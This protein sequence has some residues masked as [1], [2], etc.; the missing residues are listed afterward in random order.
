MQIKLNNI[1]CSLIILMPALLITGSFL[2]DSAV[3]L[4]DLIFIYFLFKEKKFDII[5]NNLFKLLIL[6][7]I[8]ISIRSIFTEDVLLSLK[9]SM[10]YFRFTF[11]IFA[12]GFFLHKNDKLIYYFSKGII[13]T[14]LILCLDALFQFF[15]GFNT[16]GFKIINLDKLNSFF[17]D[18]AVLGS[19]LIRFL[20]LLLACFLHLFS[21][22]KKHLFHILLLFIGVLI[23][24]SGSRSS[25]VLF[26]I[27]FLIL[28]TLFSNYRKIILINFFILMSLLTLLLLKY[29]FNK[30][31]KNQYHD[32][33]IKYKMYYNII[34]P[35]KSIFIEN[36]KTDKIIIFTKIYQTHYE[37]AYKMFNDN[38]I[39]GVGNKMY[40]KLCDDPKYYISKHSCTTH[41]HNFY[42]QIL[43]ENGLVGFLF[44]LSLFLY[45]CLQL[46][47]EFY[48]RNIKKQ[49]NLDNKSLLI[50][51]GIFLNLWPIIPSGNFYNNWLSI[52]IY[53]PIGFL[54]YF[55]NIFKIKYYGQIN[56]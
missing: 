53:F 25:F 31:S 22:N 48:Y 51:I 35:F 14:I 47:K 45:L 36:K 49:F 37:T 12:I 33:K 13:I 19:Y 2:S 50:F 27:F 55:N 42:I 56:N 52:L 24:L 32:N 54:F 40:R 46:L 41:P 21:D 11:L 20:P 28:L 26:I 29:D 43:A 34:D 8:F 3:V 9:S 16:L 7:N 6:F 1:A 17:G 39:F 44:I 5:N 23:F 10:S 4:I 30:I 15:F 18:E 38:K